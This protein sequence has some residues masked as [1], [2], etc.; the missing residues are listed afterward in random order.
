MQTYDTVVIYTHVNLYDIFHNMA[1]STIIYLF[2]FSIVVLFIK[3][4]VYTGFNMIKDMHAHAC[5]LFQMS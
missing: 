1:Q 3:Y 5:A 2:W 4:T